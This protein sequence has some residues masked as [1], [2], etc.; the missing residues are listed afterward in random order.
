MTRTITEFRVFIATPGGLSEERKAFREELRNYNDSDALRRGI[1]FSPVGWEDTLAGARRRPQSLIN[2]DLV[3]CDAFVMV[4]WDRWGSPPSLDGP[5]TSG[6]E[7]EFHLALECLEDAN[8]PMCDALVFFKAVAPRQLADPGPQLQGVLDFKRKLETEKH[9]LYKTFDEQVAFRKLLDQHLGKW[10]YQIESGVSPEPQTADASPHHPLPSKDSL[11]GR[12]D[13]DYAERLA[14]EGKLTDAEAIFAKAIVSD[15]DIESFDRY[16]QFLRRVGRLAQ[17]AVMY[18]QV[19]DVASP[20]RSDWMAIAY[21]HLGQIQQIRGDLKQA[22]SL[23][24]LALGLYQELGIKG[25]MADV[26]GNLGLICEAHGQLQEAEKMQRQALEMHEQAGSC[27]GMAKA[28]DSLGL[29]YET[30]G[31][32]KDAEEMHRKALILH[33]QEGSAEGMAAAHNNIGLIYKQRGDLEEAESMFRNAIK[34]NERLGRN[35]G[36]AIAYNNV[37]LILQELGKL[38]EAERMHQAALRINKEV[39]SREGKGATYDSLGI[40]CCRRG[41]LEEA[42]RRH[43]QALALFEILEYPEGVAEALDHLGV[44]Y[45]KRGRFLDAEG[46]HRDALGIYRKVGRREGKAEAFVNLGRTLQEQGN[47]EEAMSAWIQARTHYARLGV[48]KKTNEIDEIVDS[49]KQDLE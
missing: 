33:E 29:I 12:P 23:H 31:E 27:R 49:L 46:M 7:E 44:V 34:I 5:Y 21:N 26:Y 37:G 32:L 47:L 30:R 18:R 11:S 45:R 15:G 20:D 41:K 6:C 48:S 22:E 2:E 36:L 43:R 38:D 39:A 19:L 1:S 24:R 35:R 10:L 4:L 8:R 42:E 3:G 16:G 13:L 40:L 25:G 9:V 14:N 28:L 17:A